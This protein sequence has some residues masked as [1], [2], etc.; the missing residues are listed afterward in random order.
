VTSD[1]IV[2]HD[3]HLQMN[4]RAR[5]GALGKL[6]DC[7]RTRVRDFV[8]KAIIVLRAAHLIAKFLAAELDFSVLKAR[9][10]LYRSKRVSIRSVMTL[11]IAKAL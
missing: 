3:P 9:K 6:G 10:L 4:T 5:L 8:Q 7:P 11:L 1:F 2:L